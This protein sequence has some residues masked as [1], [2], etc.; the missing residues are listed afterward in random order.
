MN[1]EARPLR[2]RVLEVLRGKPDLKAVELA[3]V[4][5]VERREVNRC[6]SYELAGQ[7]QQGADY[8]WRLVT[9][10]APSSLPASTE[11]AS[12]IARLAR[13]YLE[14]IGQDMDEGVSAFASNRYG[15]PDYAELSALPLAVPGMPWLTEPRVAPVLGKVRQDRAKLTVWLGYPVRL[16]HHRT[17]RWEGFFVEPVLLWRVTLPEQGGEAPSIDDDAPLL[18]AKFLRSVAI[19]DSLQLADEAARLGD[20]LGLNVPIA[21]LPEADELADRLARIRPDWDWKETL[22]PADCRGAAPLSEL[23]EQGLYNRAVVLPGERSPFT[24]GLESELKALGNIAEPHLRGTALG[25]W[26]GGQA[27]GN[28]PPAAAAPDSEPLIEVLPMNSEQ[29]AAVRSAMWAP[30]TVVTG[31]PGTGKSQVVTNLLV[32][33]AWRGM[34]VL[35]ASKNNKAVDVVEARTNGLGNRP[36]LLRLGAKEYQSRLAGYL[37]QLLAGHPGEEERVGY[38]EGLQRHRSLAA[39]L[40]ELD[41]AQQQTLEARNTVDRL[42]AEADDARALFGARLVGIDEALVQ[43]VPAA[44]RALA[45]AID[46]ADRQ[47]QGW[48]T[49]L[50]WRWA[51]PP[52]LRRLESVCAAAGELAARL[53]V[54]LP[55]E[56]SEADLLRCRAGV[57]ALKQRHAAA[58]KVVAYKH[59]LEVLKRSP[60]FEDIARQKAALADEVAQNSQRLWRDWVQ[61]APT[62]LSAAQ[63]KDV[64]EY[65]TL[66][67]VMTGPDVERVPAE[68]KRR[69]R[70]LQGKVTELFA[71]WAVTSLSARGRVP[72]EPGYFD[73]VVIDEASQCDIASAMPLLYRAKRSVIIGDPQQLRH[74]SALSRA[75]DGEL[76]RKHGLVET[77]AGWMY[78]VASLYDV[79]AGVVPPENIVNLRDHHRSHADIIEFSNRTFYEGRLRV[80]TRHRRLRRPRGTE[81]GVVWQDQR[82]Q[83]VR[84]PAGGALNRPEAQAVLAALHDLLVARRYEGSVGVVTPFRAQ[85]QLLQELVAASDGLAPVRDRAELLVDTVHRFQG[86]ERDVMFFSPVVSNGTPDGALGF[87]RSNGN[88]FNVAITRA[89]GLLHVVG[90]RAA[91]ADSGVDYL[92]SFA[93]YVAG[94]NGAAPRGDEMWPGDHGPDYPRVARP[95]QVS[96]WERVLYRAM[97]AAGLR[98]IP[99]HSVEQYDLDFALIVGERRLDVEVDGERYHRSWTGE[100]C[101][102]DQ[103][104]NQ[105]LIELGWEVK[106]FWVYEVRDQL[107]ACVAEL[108]KWCEAAK[109]AGFK[110][111]IDVEAT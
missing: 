31:P 36:V 10:D 22:N 79:A 94:L 16:R 71:C 91:A 17:A 81:P 77:R 86:D 37:T 70:A 40:A 38:E 84:P 21:D 18:N 13:Y 69:A 96:D 42:D 92:A 14:C 50:T 76:L 64:Q 8:R 57:Q 3:E 106:R 63:R 87:L 47:G 55:S 107:D 26:L 72:F 29:R 108:V 34:K 104:R 2:D 27:D 100:L 6:L 60:A 35:F 33:A 44:A 99:Q 32:N 97:Y 105:R 78:S 82:G 1:V 95:E 103:L 54:R 110:N 75:R 15:A 30:H 20:E 53:G 28:V 5:G 49:R 62:R 24:L 61:L 12:E 66:L 39:R 80:A 7:V 48:W 41:R 45:A 65:A 67:Q 19:G 52:R 59:A 74:I 111:A 11:P 83:V 56:P 43:R 109:T 89:R 25:R 93:G 23:D 101:L 98:P 90:D 9:R 51:A 4:L 85:A 102:R 73:L 46:A 68:V 88:L 58:S